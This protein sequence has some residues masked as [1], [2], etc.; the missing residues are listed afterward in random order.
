MTDTLSRILYIDLSDGRSW[1]EDRRDLF[2]DR[3]GGL[4]VA[5]KLYS[6][7]C[8]L[9]SDPFDPENPVVFTVGPLNGLYPSI[10]K[11]VAVFKSPITGT[12]G[13][14]HAGGRL[15]IAIRMAGYGAIVIIG[16]SDKPVFI[17]IEDS[18]VRFRDA[19]P[20][21]GLSS[22]EVEERLRTCTRAMESI[23]SI[24]LAGER[25]CFYA[26]VNVDRYNYFGR[27]GLGAILGSRN[28]KALR[29]R[30]SGSIKPKDPEGY[31][32]LFE[33]LYR[34]I[35][36]TDAMAKYHYTG[37]PANIMVL[38]EIGALPTRNFRESKFEYAEDI[39]GEK[40]GETLL[41]RKA[42][43]PLCPI[44]CMHI[45]RLRLEFARGYEYEPIDV[46]YNY[47]SMYALGTN[48]GLKNPT[49]ILRLIY[50]A[51]LY[52]FDTMLLGNVLAWMTEAYE[53]GLISDSDT[54]GLKLSWGDI[55]PYL[56]AVKR[57]AYG[58]KDLYIY[59]AQGLKQ[60]TDVYGGRDY[61][62]Q[63]AGNGMPGYHTGYASIIGFLV[64]SRHSHNSNAGYDIDQQALKRR[65]TDE[66]FIDRI[67]EEEDWRN[68][69]VSL[70]AC[71]FSR[72][73]YSP[74]V[75]IDALKTV[76]FDYSLDELIRIG[77]EIYTDIYRI[78]S[79]EG[80][81]PR[82]IYVPRRLF[83]TPSASGILSE[84]RFRKLLD[85]YMERRSISSST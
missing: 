77:K 48:L 56:E 31:R 82:R 83:E 43:C 7:K 11:T 69:L 62:I 85:L 19:K 70:V 5:V 66:E 20:L 21:L 33:K 29:I 64:A 38:N 50:T 25:V 40:I 57:I 32:R 41:E 81:D 61:A 22:L 80:F 46:Y 75:V 24:G 52:G 79:S 76:G 16:Y 37:T 2:D 53:S 73:V 71:M 51:N 6:E 34:V 45:A 10:S 17:D 3:I 47:E 42:S 44:G 39:S 27:L 49:D 26:S 28:V 36:E 1:V 15:S 12:Y 60:L 9:G 54:N 8:K 58:D 55:D 65:Y 84:E 78:K 18:N 4:G 68:I 72:R 35:V 23:V 63:I 59:A 67:I 30:G 13:E 14:S 74:D